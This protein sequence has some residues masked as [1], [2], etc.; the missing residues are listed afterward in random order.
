MPR[1]GQFSPRLIPIINSEI[2]RKF[3]SKVQTSN[4]EAV[5]ASKIVQISGSLLSGDEFRAKVE[6]IDETLSF[7]VKVGG[8]ILH[9]RL[10]E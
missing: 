4:V 10:N 5:P 6:E 9:W 2:G 8:R 7:E 1:D 3:D